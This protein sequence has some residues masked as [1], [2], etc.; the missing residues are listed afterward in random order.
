MGP[1]AGRGEAAR[2]HSNFHWYAVGYAASEGAA[3]A[4]SGFL[5]LSAR[6]QPALEATEI[7]HVGITHI[8]EGLAD[9][10]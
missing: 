10:R 2:R 4:Q 8:L 1:L 7:A 3:K 6:L 9:E 5:H